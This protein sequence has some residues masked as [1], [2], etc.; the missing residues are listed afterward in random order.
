MMFCQ[1]TF[2]FRHPQLNLIQLLLKQS[3]YI[4]FSLILSFTFIYY[5][6]KYKF[7]VTC[8][9]CRTFCYNHEFLKVISLPFFL[10]A[11]RLCIFASPHITAILIYSTLKSRNVRKPR[12]KK[13]CVS[14]V[15]HVEL[16][17]GF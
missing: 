8:I 13:G 14:M 5:K 3:V 11:H 15:P 1:S 7:L 16:Q 17:R 9:Q 2:N 4:T 6:E 10:I 12:V